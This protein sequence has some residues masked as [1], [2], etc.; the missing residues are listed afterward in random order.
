A[1]DV[2]QDARIEALAFDEHLGRLRA[3]LLEGER[4]VAARDRRREDPLGTAPQLA[5]ADGDH[6]ASASTIASASHVGTRVG[7]WSPTVTHAC[8]VQPSAIRCPSRST[9]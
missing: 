4:E 8:V 2:L 1:G 3:A 9:R 6:A 7:R 5:V